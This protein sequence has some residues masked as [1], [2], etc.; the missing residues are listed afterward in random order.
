MSHTYV[1][2]SHDFTITKNLK[3]V[4]KY[5]ETDSMKHIT[6]DSK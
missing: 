6:I 1:K 3:A 2:F 5:D 4:M